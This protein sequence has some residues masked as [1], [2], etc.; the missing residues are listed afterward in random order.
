[1]KKR[2]RT[3]SV[4]RKKGFFIAL[5]SCLGVVAT[6]AV[7]VTVTNNQDNTGDFI[8]HTPQEEILAVGADQVESYLADFD[9]EAWFR[10]RNTEDNTPTQPTEPLTQPPAPTQPYTQPAPATEPA[11][12][13]PPPEAN[14]APATEPPTQPP[15]VS[16]LPVEPMPDTMYVPSFAPFA[17]GNQM[18]WP[19]QGETLMPFSNT[20]LVYDPTLDQFRTNDNI[21]IAAEEGDAV[22]AGAYGRVIATGRSARQGSYIKVDHG[23]GWTAVYAQLMDTKLVEVGDIVYA[24]QVIGGVGQPSIFGSA[25]GPHL[26]L[27]IEQDSVAVN[28]YDVLVARGY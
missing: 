7:V 18:Y 28:P 10:P 20:A 13:A 14:V 3:E 1:M 21:R 12:T 27:R 17:E 11:T 19:V 22:R 16:E 23:N 25:H 5:Y 24:G 4:F 9:H 8:A 2:S 26:H 6:L 15:T